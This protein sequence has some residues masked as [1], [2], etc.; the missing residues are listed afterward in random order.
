VQIDWDVIRGWLR[1]GAKEGSGET[2][3]ALLER[4]KRVKE[5]L[6]TAKPTGRPAPIL[7]SKKAAPAIPKPESP[8][9]AAPPSPTAEPASTT[10]R[11]LARKRK[12]EQDSEQG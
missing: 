4:K 2:M 3:G 10:E 6:D 9:P 7:L 5:T 8:K 11:L 1:R 12:R